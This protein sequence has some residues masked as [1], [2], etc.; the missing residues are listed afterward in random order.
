MDPNLKAAVLGTGDVQAPAS[1][2]GASNY[3]AISGLNHIDYALPQSNLATNA[4]VNIS[5]QQDKAAKEATALAAQKAQDMLD[6]KRYRVVPGKDGGF[7]FYAP[8]GTQVDIATLTQRTGTKPSDWLTGS[9]N[10]IDTQ[11]LADT[12]NLTGLIHAVQSKDTSALARY[13]K[14]FTDNG[15][16]DATKMKVQDILDQYKSYYQRFYVPRS[17]DQQAWGVAPKSSPFVP[18]PQYLSAADKAAAADSA[19]QAQVDNYQP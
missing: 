10:P 1:T 9:E 5:Q 19:S 12:K 16:P 7:N 8:D 2:L 13:S 4:A 15:L 14:G 17:Q 18:A 11:Y 3:A 6:P